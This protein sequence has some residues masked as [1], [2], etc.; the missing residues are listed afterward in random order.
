[1]SENFLGDYVQNEN[2]CQRLNSQ[3]E[4]ERCWCETKV[5]LFIC[6]AEETSHQ[7]RLDNGVTT[8]EVT[9]SEENPTTNLESVQK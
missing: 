9:V 7:S 6:D 4:V 3:T 2:L 5:F 8:V 1:M